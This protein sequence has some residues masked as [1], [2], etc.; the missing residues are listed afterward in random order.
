MKNPDW[1]GLINGKISLR[2]R[3][4]IRQLL[5]QFG[6]DSSITEYSGH[7]DELLQQTVNYPGII[8][9]GGDGTLHEVINGIDLEQQKILVIPAGT[10]NCFARFIGIRSVQDG[11]KLLDE[12]EVQKI[13][14]L[15]TDIYQEDGNHE[16]RYVW[17]FLTFGRLVSITLLASKF[18]ALPKFFRYF[19]STMINHFISRKT[20][21]VIS[22]NGSP[23]GTCKFSSLI[24]NNATSGHFSSIPAWNMQDGAAEM[25]MVNHNPVTQFFASFSRFIK[26][27]VNLSW[28]NGVHSLSCEF[29]KPAKMMADGE[30]IS[31]IKKIEVKVMPEVCEVMVPPG[32][33]MNYRIFGFRGNW[34]QFHGLI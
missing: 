29:V 30:I 34:K 11:I 32:T 21:A 33:D 10:I 19:L 4:S 13:D 16:K 1:W 3:R 6:I 23:S 27:P 31:G 28:I 20:R 22:V 5:Q 2:R 7:A 25:Q 8:S 26:I 14:L 15:S 18:T 12:G 17:G 24:L 9:I